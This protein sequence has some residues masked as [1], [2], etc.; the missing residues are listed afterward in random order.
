MDDFTTE[1]IIS[2][3]NLCVSLSEEEKTDLKIR[4]MDELEVRGNRLSPELCAELAETFDREQD[5][6][7]SIALPDYEQVEQDT[8]D[9]YEGEMERIRPHLDEL[10]NEYRH[11]T[12]ELVREYDKAFMDL[13]KQFDQV[14]QKEVAVKESEQIASLRQ[15]LAGPSSKHNS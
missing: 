8:Q 5:Y 6:L 15:K 4:V 14:T 1:D 11:E 13:D 7:Q 12:E 3:I 9:E 10:V 2:F